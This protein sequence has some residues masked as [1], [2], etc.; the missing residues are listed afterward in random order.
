MDKTRRA[1]E[2]AEAIIAETRSVHGMVESKV[3]ALSACT[4]AS[5]RHMVEVL[6]EHVQEMA[7]ETET[8]TPCAVGTVVQQLEKEIAAAATRTAVTA[9][10]P[11]RIV[12]EGMR[13]DV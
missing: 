2:V 3:A 8:K 1:R 6:S 4:D 12:V 10:I 11:M 13:R 7:V 9:E 5:T